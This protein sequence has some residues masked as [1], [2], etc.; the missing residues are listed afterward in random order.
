MTETAETHTCGTGCRRDCTCGRGSYCH[1]RH[2]SCYE[3]FLDRRADFASCIYCGKWHSPEFDTCFACRPQGRDEAA[4]NLK[5]EILARDSFTCRYCGAGQGDMQSDP[6][7]VTP[8]DPYG[9]R[10]AVMHVDHVLPCRHGGTADPWNLQ[11]LCG[12][13]NTSKGDEWWPGCRHQK[14]RRQIADAY[15]T[16]LWDFLTATQKEALERELTRSRMEAFPAAAQRIFEDYREAVSG[17]RV[18]RLPPP[19]EIEDVPAEYAHLDLPTHRLD[20]TASIGTA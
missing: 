13:C 16:Y 7:K 3:C 9:L 14:Q 20:G 19:L 6:R 1:T 15:V 10:P 18:H 5:L 17:P 2:K 4:R 8:Q 12:V 11:V